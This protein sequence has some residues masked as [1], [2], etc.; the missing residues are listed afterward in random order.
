MTNIVLLLLIV[1]VVLSVAGVSLFGKDF[2][3]FF[4]NLGAGIYLQSKV[5]FT[6]YC[7][8]LQSNMFILIKCDSKHKISRDGIYIIGNHLAY[9]A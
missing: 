2:P 9:W 5:Y 1:M 4:E 7:L 3:E 8:S 6:M